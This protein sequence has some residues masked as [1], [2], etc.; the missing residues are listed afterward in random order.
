[1]KYQLLEHGLG[2]TIT[3]ETSEEMKNP[4][5]WK[6]VGGKKMMRVMGRNNPDHQVLKFRVGEQFKYFGEVKVIHH[7]DY[8]YY[9]AYSMKPN[10]RRKTSGYFL[11]RVFLCA[12]DGKRYRAEEVD[13]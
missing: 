10:S 2:F 12:E 11:K 1:M 3:A 5:L 6:G 8:L 7:I 4:R 13:A 9:G